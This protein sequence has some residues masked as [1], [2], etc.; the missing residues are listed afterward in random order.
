M[1]CHYHESSEAVKSCAKCGKSLCEQ[2]YHTDLPDYCWGC[3]LDHSNAEVE[4]EKGMQVPASLQSGVGAYVV[5]KFAA[6]GGT[7]MVV[8]LLL[9]LVFMLAGPTVA[10]AVGLITALTVSSITYT[11][12]IVFSMLA[13]WLLKGVQLDKK[14]YP[15]LLYGIGGALYPYLVHMVVGLSFGFSVII[16]IISALIFCGVQGYFKPQR[17][18]LSALIVAIVAFITAGFLLTLNGFPFPFM[19]GRW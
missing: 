13:D 2:C 9:T 15:A 10:M 16:S 3:G 1:Q 17:R 12:G 8:S 5:L 19:W 4:R 18:R 6:A 7:Y 11:Y 14:I